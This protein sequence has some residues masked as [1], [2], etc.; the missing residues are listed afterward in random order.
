MDSLKIIQEKENPVFKRKGVTIEIHSNKVP[1]KEEVTELI[2]KK[3]SV[4][5]NLIAIEKI[6]GK[7]GSYSILVSAKIYNSE[8]DKDK[9]EPKSKK[10]K[11]S[12]AP[13]QATQ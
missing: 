9:I 1:S 13:A 10:G 3:F 6:Q 5:K 4:E 12:E 7:F 8:Q 2:A 11:K